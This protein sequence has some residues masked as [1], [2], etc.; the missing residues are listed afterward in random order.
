MMLRSLRKT[1]ADLGEWTGEYAV[2]TKAMALDG[3]YYSGGDCPDFFFDYVTG[4]MVVLD[5]DAIANATDRLLDMDV[6]NFTFKKR[7]ENQ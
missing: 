7:Q 2:P 1:A 4:A 5:A 6:P 3:V